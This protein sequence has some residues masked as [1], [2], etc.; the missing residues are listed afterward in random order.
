MRERCVWCPRLRGCVE[1]AGLR[2]TLTRQTIHHPKEVFRVVGRNRGR[3]WGCRRAQQEGILFWRGEGVEG[4]WNHVGG[5]VGECMSVALV[6]WVGQEGG[7]RLS[8]CIG[9]L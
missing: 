9:G 7:G 5:G 4:R 8:L 6:M 2:L 3:E 1:V